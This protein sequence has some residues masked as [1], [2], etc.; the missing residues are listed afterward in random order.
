M[1]NN[2]VVREYRFEATCEVT[3]QPLPL[4]VLIC[5]YHRFLDG[6]ALTA[7]PAA[8]FLETPALNTL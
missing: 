2:L 8:I 1:T 3:G 4:I 7:L 5:P 6:N